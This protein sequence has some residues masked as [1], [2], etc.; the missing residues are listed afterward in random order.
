MIRARPLPRLFALAVILG[1]AVITLIGFSAVRRDTDNLELID[2]DHVV[3]SASQVELELMRFQ[4]SFADLAAEASQEALGKT[5]VRFDILWNR[6][7]MLDTGGT[8]EI[9]RQHDMGFGAVGALCRY[10]LKLDPILRDLDPADGATIA[11]LRGE[12]A[13]FRESLRFFTLRAMRG[14][15]EATAQVRDRLRVSAL[16]T[17]L[18]SLACVLAG[19]LLLMLIQRQTDRQEQ[20]AAMNRSMAQEAREATRLK[21]R[22]L[23]MVSHELR[24]PLN[25]VLGPLALLDQS[26]LGHNHA[27]LVRQAQQSGAEIV[28]MLASL[29][30]YGELQDGKVDF[31]AVPFRTKTLAHRLRAAVGEEIAGPRIAFDPAMPDRLI[32]DL[33][34]FQQIFVNLLEFVCEQTDRC[35][36]VLRLRYGASGLVGEI[37]YPGAALEL[38]SRFDRMTRLAALDGDQVSV[39]AIRPLI[40]RGLIAVGA[41]HCDFIDLRAGR[42]ALRVTLPADPA[43]SQEV[44]VHLATR[45]TALSAIYR[46]ALRTAQF[47]FVDVVGEP[48][49]VV[50]TDATAIGDDPLMRGLRVRF[51]GAIFI[52]LGAPPDPALFDHVFDHAGDFQSLRQEIRQKFAC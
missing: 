36:V 8:G 40:A 34:R 30:E 3:W 10:L 32:G 5:R 47:R 42:A 19:T 21:S 46:A 25:G 24:N 31:D 39:E 44:R 52:S 48:A 14:D 13:Q 43:P 4:L 1:M 2:Q 35:A 50:L 29:L 20:V 37:V 17:A 49:D 26:G 22:F 12:L 41:G 18:V 27:R 51:P 45:S 23:S 28:R 33:D 38:G 6:A 11:R 16:L 15:L 7:F 9:L